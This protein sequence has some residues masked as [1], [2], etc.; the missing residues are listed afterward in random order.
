MGKYYL[1]I[2]FIPVILLYPSLP[3]LIFS[4]PVA[5]CKSN[6][7]P[8]LHI[9]FTESVSAAPRKTSIKKQRQRVL[10][11]RE[12]IQE[13]KSK[14]KDSKQKEEGLLAELERLD[15][16][17]QVQSYKLTTLI[18]S[19]ATQEKRILNEQNNLDQL[20]AKREAMKSYIEKRLTAYYQMG[21]IGFMNVIFSKK[22]LGDLLNFQE[23]FHYLV[24]NDKEAIASYHNKIAEQELIRKKL[25]KEKEF[26]QKLVTRVAEKEKT[27][28]DTKQ[29]KKNLLRRVKT[30]KKLFAQ[31]M[32]EIEKAATDLTSSI[33]KLLKTNKKTSKSKKSEQ[34]T[35]VV[36]NKKKKSS[37]TS[38][39]ISQKGELELP[40]PGVILT[41]LKKNQKELLRAAGFSMGIDILPQKNTNITAIYGGRI[42]NSGYLRGYG[43]M[44]I[45]DHGQQ[46]YSIISRAAQLL[47]EEGTS[48]A[49]GEPIGITG[50]NEELLGQGIHFE[51]RHGSSPEN[52][53][54]WL[55]VDKLTFQERN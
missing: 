24:E 45:I 8:S 6:S 43:N 48:V 46:Y 47:K 25:E 42:V 54:E 19:Y 20:I 36:Q 51:I 14:L 37:H 31:A 21:G 49:K 15:N 4:A 27:L 28:A 23:Y 22:N 53:M 9:A 44:L 50:D 55:N 52:P 34:E 41:D 39:F 30:E 1:I 40:V 38:G 33:D 35:A 12:G 3:V 10:R 32:T 5:I 18:E 29:E 13:H 26:L 17:L 11:L 7:F 16:K 2:F